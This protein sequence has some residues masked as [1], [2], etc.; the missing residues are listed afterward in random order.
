MCTQNHLLSSLLLIFWEKLD[1]DFGKRNIFSEIL[2]SLTKFLE[3][4]S[5][6]AQFLFQIILNQSQCLQIIYLHDTILSVHVTSICWV[7]F[8][9]IFKCI[10]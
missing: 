2:V 10:H 8:V 5:K 4:H 6:S 7:T 3:K 1:K 9:M